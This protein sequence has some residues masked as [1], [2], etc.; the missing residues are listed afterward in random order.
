M[1]DYPTLHLYINKSEETALLLL[2]YIM[3]ILSS[4]QVQSCYKTF[5]TNVHT[6]SAISIQDF[7][8]FRRF[9]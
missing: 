3:I 1:R 6:T 8:A 4:T 9:Q 7:A 2:F 5:P